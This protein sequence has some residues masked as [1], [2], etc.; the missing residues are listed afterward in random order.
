MNVW[1]LILKEMVHRWVNFVLAGMAV[2]LAVSSVVG[3]TLFL[4]QFNH[5]S[6]AMIAAKQSAVEQQIAEMEDEFRVI[7]K[8]MGFNILILPKAQSLADFY[9]ESYADETMPESYAPLLAAA[10]DIV[11]IRHL[12]PMLQA[13]VEWSEKKRKVLLIGVKGEMPW[14]HRSNLKPIMEPVESGKIAVGYELH[15]SLSL[16]QGDI[17]QVQGKAFEISI[18]HPERGTIDDITLWTSLEDAQQML[19]KAGLISAMMALECECAWANLPKVRQEIQ[20]ILPETQVIELSGKAL[21]RAEARRSAADNAQALLDR[22]KANR[23]AMGRQ[24][25]RMIASI[26]PLVLTACALVVGVLAWVNVRERRIEIG[27]L[28]AM[29][30]RTRSIA[31]VFMGKA[32]LL[33]LLG[34]SLG[35]LLGA[36]L[37]LALGPG[38]GASQRLQVAVSLPWLIAVLCLTPVVTLGASW[39]P[40]LWAI[41]QDPAAVLCE[42]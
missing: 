1:H 32:A 29:G 15:R 27:I 28:R 41:Q 14:A 3:S 35:V 10:P 31:V 13:K 22:E 18:L 21:A 16:N 19:G 7:T 6:E 39:V 5:V 11:T 8:R 38:Q 17:I 36:G 26:V 30:L 37:F 20:A 33:G 24:R 12:L 4:Q 23:M 2:V 25:E 40:I 34:G 9:A 42:E